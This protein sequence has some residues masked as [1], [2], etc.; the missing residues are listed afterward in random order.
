MLTKTLREFLQN[1]ESEISPN[2]RNVNLHR[3][4]K[5]V[6]QA[7]NDLELIALC[8]PTYF[9]EN[10]F[11]EGTI[12]PFLSAVLLIPYISP[13]KNQHPIVKDTRLWNLSLSL[14]ELA[15]NGGSKLVPELITLFRKTGWVL[16]DDTKALIEIDDK[17]GLKK[18]R[19]DWQFDKIEKEYKSAQT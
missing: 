10:I 9:Q 6:I 12:M 5:K 3:I 8:C 1:P 15:V 4:K 2:Q 17:Y 14:L 13:K 11:T 19:K 18:T 16:L 7:L